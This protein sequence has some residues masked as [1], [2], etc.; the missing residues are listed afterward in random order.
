[1]DKDSL[2]ML[3]KLIAI[4]GTSGAFGFFNVL[5]LE[6]THIIMFDGKANKDRNIM[7][8]SFSALNFYLFI[9]MD[10]IHRGVWSLIGLILLSLG[11]TIIFMLIYKFGFPLIRELL[12]WVSTFKFSKWLLSKT[13]GTQLPS[14]DVFIDRALPNDVIVITDFEGNF[15]DSGTLEGASASLFDS[16]GVRLKHLKL[17]NE[18]Y[19]NSIESMNRVIKKHDDELVTVTYIDLNNKLKYYL[20]T[21]RID[22]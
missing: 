11:I 4:L 9:Y 14:W 19:I 2:D 21:K 16:Q 8:A 17:D 12:K 22:A 3:S 18:T 6:Q 20:L 13:N 1:M 10:P 7:L 5:L 15:I